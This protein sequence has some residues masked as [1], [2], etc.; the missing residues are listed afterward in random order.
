MLGRDDGSLDHEDVEAGLERRF[1][2]GDHLLGGQGGG[3]HH[4]AGLDL[5]DALADQLGLEGLPVDL[6]H[7][8]RGRILR[9]LGDSG[10]LVVGV[11]VAGED[12]LEV[13]HGQAAEPP[14]LDRRGRRDDSVHGGGQ[15]RQLEAVRA[16]L[17]GDVDVVGV[18]GP[19]R[20]HD[21]DVVE[22]V[23]APGLLAP[24]NLNFHKRTLGS[25][26]DETAQPGP[27]AR[28]WGPGSL[29]AWKPPFDDTAQRVAAGASTGSTRTSSSSRSTPAGSTRPAPSRWVDSAPQAT[30]YRRHSLGA[31]PM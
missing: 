22:A 5:G 26:A 11:G 14:D 1:V 3:R 19:P 12:A 15:E 20:G 8:A 4:P 23:S 16:E 17:P 7:L 27:C 2:V 24:A 9:Q 29:A 25:G 13:E 21:G 10:E 30:A 18:A 31:I 28:R 6:L